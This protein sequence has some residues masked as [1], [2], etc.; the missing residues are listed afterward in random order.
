MSE[1]PLFF[2]SRSGELFGTLHRPEGPAREIGFVFCSPLLEEK[3]WA[4]RL[5]V[6]FARELAACGYAV[7]RFDYMGHG[8]SDGVFEDASINTRLADIDAAA[9]NLLRMTGVE[10]VGLL[11]LR[12]GATLAAVAA[13]LV[14]DKYRDL[15][16]WEPLPK[17]SAYMQ[18]LLRINLAT[19][20]ASYK[21]IRVNRKVMA[22]S[23]AD[24]G[25]VNVDGYGLTG[26]L[27]QEAQGINLL[28]GPRSYRGRTL[29]VHL[30]RQAEAIAPVLE[31]LG[32]LYAS[33][34]MD[35][36]AVEPFWK[37]IKAYVPS[38]RPLY[39]I[40]RRWLEEDRA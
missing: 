22:A 30:H 6:N 8:D 3:L 9:D 1:L 33:V 29:I 10:K 17:G 25:L 4:H 2:P 11:G 34:R 7:I 40:T 18:E 19:Q 38:C 21:E 16:L 23:L 36:V 26:P 39:D 32:A 15:I 28:D 24:G 20:M 14:P 31:Q 27:F 37:E 5:F 12:F 35:K 13:D